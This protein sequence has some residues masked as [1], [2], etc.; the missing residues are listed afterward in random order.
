MNLSEHF[1]VA[2]M[3]F[4]QTAVRKG[5]SNNPPP[6]AVAALEKL[7]VNVLEPVRAHF[8]KPVRISSGYRSQALN[9]AVGGSGTSEHCFGRAADIVVPGVDNLRLAKWIRDNLSFRQVIMEGSWVHVSYNPEDNK[10]QA[11]TAHFSGGRA[12]YTEGL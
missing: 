11:L 7:C 1:S 5:I 3:T 12:S 8:G 6:Q 10:K 2:E 4:S 9:K